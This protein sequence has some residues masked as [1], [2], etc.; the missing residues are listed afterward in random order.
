[1]QFF[2]SDPDKV[3][4]KFSARVLAEL[5]QASIVSSTVEQEQYA[6]AGSKKESVRDA[7][8]YSFGGATQKNRLMVLNLRMAGSRP[9]SISA[10]VLKFVKLCLGELVYAVPLGG[11]V[12]GSVKLSKTGAKARFEGDSAAAAA[13]DAR[14]ELLAMAR[15]MLVGSYQTNAA[16]ISSEPGLAIE[17]ADKGSVLL[18]RTLPRATWLSM[19]I[20]AIGIKLQLPLLLDLAATIESTLPNRAAT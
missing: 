6:G 7:L 5:P 11:A 12:G 13:L 14:P 3:L 15:K 17:P 20:P 18:V 4:A 8:I 10:S 1:M 2:S 9:F 16:T 19:F